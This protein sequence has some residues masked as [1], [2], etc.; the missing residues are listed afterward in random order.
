MTKYLI[1][2]QLSDEED[3]DELHEAIE[4]YGD[5]IQIMRSIWFIETS[6]SRTDVRDNLS[7]YLESGDTLFVMDKSAWAAWGLDNDDVDWLKN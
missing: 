5:Y 1:T 4:A 6:S 2:Y 3:Y 7:D